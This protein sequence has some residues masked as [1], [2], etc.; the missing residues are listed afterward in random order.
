MYLCFWLNAEKHG[1]AANL[2][3]LS[4][5]KARRWRGGVCTYHQFVVRW[6]R[7]RQT[8]TDFLQ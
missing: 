1:I 6:R 7:Q 5:Q 8:G 4:R 3:L 2:P